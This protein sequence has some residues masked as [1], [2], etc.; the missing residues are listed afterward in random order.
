MVQATAVAV[1]ED[2]MEMFVAQ[3]QLE[4]AAAILKVVEVKAAIEKCKEFKSMYM[5]D[6]VTPIPG[7]E[8]PN[9]Q[10]T[11]PRLPKCFGKGALCLEPGMVSSKVVQ[12]ISASQ[13]QETALNMFG[14]G[15]VLSTTASAST[16]SSTTSQSTLGT[17]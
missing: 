15:K 3:K 10:V 11:D 16:T 4:K 2:E 12:Q 13:E 7:N 9:T 14:A 1:H 6:G 5:P 8:S 17:F